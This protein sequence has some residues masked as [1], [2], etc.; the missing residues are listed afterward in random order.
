MTVRE[1][2]FGQGGKL[3]REGQAEPTQE[4][5]ATFRLSESFW[6]M[7]VRELK[8]QSWGLASGAFLMLLGAAMA[9]V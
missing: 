4:I 6:A 3:T 2:E 8:A 7:I 5:V 9:G 1:I